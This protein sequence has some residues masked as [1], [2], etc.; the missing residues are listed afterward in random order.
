M[1]P[2]NSLVMKN[3]AK[4]KPNLTNKERNTHP[5]TELRADSRMPNMTHS[6]TP[7]E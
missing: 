2:A 5:R 1:K 4:N 7:K 6:L 3:N